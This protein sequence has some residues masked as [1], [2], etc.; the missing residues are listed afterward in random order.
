MISKVITEHG[1]V[2]EGYQ[3]RLRPVISTDLDILRTWRNSAFVARQMLSTEHISEVQQQQWFNNIASLPSQQHWVVEYRGNPIGATNV[4]SADGNTA[5]EQASVLEPGLY[6][7]DAAY[8]GNILAFAPTL[9]LYDYCFGDLG[10]S[11]FRAVVKTDNLAALKYNQQLGYGVVSEGELVELH[12][13]ADAY[14][15]QTSALRQLLS[16][17]RSNNKKRG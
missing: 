10:T 4:K 7:G 2:I 5:I 14:Q 8:Q 15:R 3:V 6:I 12:L 9:A 16:R 11:Y 13:H 1:M 17:P